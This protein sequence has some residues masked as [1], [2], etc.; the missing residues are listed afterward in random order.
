MKHIKKVIYLIAIIIMASVVKVNA[1]TLN[2]NITPSSNKVVVGNTVT[3]TVTISSNTLLGSLRYNFSYDSSKLT[4]VSGSTLNDAPYFNGNKKS[5]TYTFKFKAKASGTATVKFNIYEAIDWDLNNFSYNST[6]SKTTAIITQ[7][8]LEASY[9]K[10]NYLSNLKVDNYSITPKFNKSTSN[11]SLTLENDVREINISGSKDDSKSTVSGLGKHTLE[12][13]DNKI[14]IVVTAQN[15]S[16]RTYT[17]NVTVRELSPIVVNVNGN[18]LNVVRKRELL[19]LPNSNYK[20]TTVKINEEEVPAFINN[21][22]NTTLV[23]LKDKEGKVSLY[24]YDGKNYKEYKEYSFDSIIITEAKSSDIPEG[25]EE[26]KIKIGDDEITAYKSK[27]Q[28]NDYYL[29]DAI[30]ISTGEENIYQYNKKENTIQIFNKDLLNKIDDLEGKNQSY[31]YA[32]VFLGALLIVTYLVLLIMNIKKGKK[33]KKKSEI[34]ENNDKLSSNKDKYDDFD[35]DLG[36]KTEKDDKIIE[37]ISKSKKK[38]K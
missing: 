28:N 30:N 24:L 3:Y 34:K 35:K 19:Q 27:T 38:K 20:E 1:A 21:T 31:M 11:Y 12:E 18:S 15:G 29:I 23:G 33:P 9:S 22:T 4:Y 2:V 37:D 7:A 36:K 25:Y 8:E 10:N 14:N 13:G 5:A 32:I 6:T 26:T 17:L 16:S